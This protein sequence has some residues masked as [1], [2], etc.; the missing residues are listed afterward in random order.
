M[1]ETVNKTLKHSYQALIDKVKKAVESNLELRQFGVEDLAR[2]VGMSRS[3]IYRKLR[4]ISNQS[5]SRFIRE[6]R[7]DKAMELLKQN[8]GSVSEV[9]PILLCF[10]SK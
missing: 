3:L 6:I 9:R 4:S 7:L 1:T 10:L 2:E 8:E 5:V